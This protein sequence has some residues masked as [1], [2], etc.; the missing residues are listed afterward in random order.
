MRPKAEPTLTFVKK[1]PR[2]PIF[3]RAGCVV[4]DDRVVKREIHETRKGQGT[5]RRD[6]SEYSIERE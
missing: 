4:A 3:P 6:L 1:S 2:L 5:L